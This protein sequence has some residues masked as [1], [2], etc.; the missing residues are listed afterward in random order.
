M[1]IMVMNIRVMKIKWY[2]YMPSHCMN[3]VR[4]TEC[5]PLY[6]PMPM[7]S[8]YPVKRAHGLAVYHFIVVTL[9]VLRIFVWFTHAYSSSRSTGI[10]AIGRWLTQCRCQWRKFWRIW[11]E[12]SSNGNISRVTDPLWGELTSNYWIPLTKAIDAELWFFLWSMPWINGWTNNRE[13]GD[14][15]RHRAHYDVT[16]MMTPNRSETQPSP[17]CVLYSWGVF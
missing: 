14:L 10:G 5:S 12:S 16:V 9:L 4:V 3:Y 7:C 6:I 17:N 8:V 2:M 11:E 13:A 15:G 1:V